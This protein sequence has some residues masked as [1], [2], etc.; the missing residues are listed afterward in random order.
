MNSCNKRII[1]DNCILD[2]VSGSRLKRIKAEVKSAL[3]YLYR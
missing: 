3:L 1:S 2:N